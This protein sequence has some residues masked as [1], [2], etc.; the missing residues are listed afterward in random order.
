VFLEDLNTGEKPYDRALSKSKDGSITSLVI[1]F[2]L[3]CRSGLAKKMVPCKVAWLDQRSKGR[4][5]ATT[6]VLACDL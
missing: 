4:L 3:S 5:F 6:A 2:A 1:G